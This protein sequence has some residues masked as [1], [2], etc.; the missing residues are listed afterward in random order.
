MGLP[1]LSARKNFNV[2]IAFAPSHFTFLLGLPEPEVLVQLLLKLIF[3][4]L[5]VGTTETVLVLRKQQNRKIEENLLQLRY[6]FYEVLVL[7]YIL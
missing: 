5:L 1:E 2:A 6:D 3:I 4:N 7:G